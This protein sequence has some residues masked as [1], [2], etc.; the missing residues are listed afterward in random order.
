MYHKLNFLASSLAPDYSANGYMRGNLA[1]LTV[2]GYLYEQPGIIKSINYSVPQ[3]S[4]WEIG[5]DNIGVNDINDGID[6]GVNQLPHMIKVTGFQFVPIHT[7]VPKLQQNTYLM[8]DGGTLDIFGKE[9]YISLKHEDGKDNYPNLLPLGEVIPEDATA[10][11]Q[12]LP[13]SQQ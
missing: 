3:E 2:G 12:D 11:E 7:F 4:P 10:L 13:A 8:D 6:R 9:K 1:T 5:I